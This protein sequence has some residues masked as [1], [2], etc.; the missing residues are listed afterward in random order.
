MNMFYRE[1][2][3]MKKD[4]RTIKYIGESDIRGFTVSFQIQILRTL[5]KRGLLTEQQCEKGIS[6]LKERS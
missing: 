1:A 6:L 3:A 5:K 4:I 2:K